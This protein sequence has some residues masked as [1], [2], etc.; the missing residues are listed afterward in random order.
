MSFWRVG[1]RNALGLRVRGKGKIDGTRFGVGND[2]EVKGLIEGGSVRVNI[3]GWKRGEGGCELGLVFREGEEFN[4]VKRPKRRFRESAGR[5]EPGSPSGAELFEV[6]WRG[7]EQGYGFGRERIPG[8][9][10]EAGEEKTVYP[11]QYI[12][13]G[14]EFE[15]RKHEVVE[16]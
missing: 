5:G 11:A 8:V 15:R 6:G 12:N 3:S 13:F 10:E 1:G 16:S 9:F 7:G 14:E 4:G 2:P